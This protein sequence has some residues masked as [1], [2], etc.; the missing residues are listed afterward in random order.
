MEHRPWHLGGNGE[1][2]CYGIMSVE[3][4]LESRSESFF[5]PSRWHVTSDV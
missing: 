1:T 5:L 4:V 2:L 3:L